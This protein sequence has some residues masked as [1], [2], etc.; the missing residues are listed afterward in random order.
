MTARRR[1][2]T[3][4]VD[5][6]PDFMIDAAAERL[7]AAGVKSTWFVTHSS[8]AVER[9]RTCSDLF[10]LGIH[11]NFR[12]GSSH[13]EDE[14]QVLDACLGMVPEAVSVRC[15]GLLQSS[16]LLNLFIER[17]PLRVCANVFLPGAAGLEVTVYRCKKGGIKQLPFYWEDDVEFFEPEPAWN[18]L[19]RSRDA[20]GIQIFNFHPVHVYLNAA[21]PHALE[22]LLERCPDLPAATRTHTEGLVSHADGA[23]S[24]FEALVTCIAGD[25]GGYTVSEL[26]GESPKVVPRASVS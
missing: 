19:A 3:L 20:P 7:V 17:T 11:P 23:G 16:R 12:P 9:L 14:L 4:D 15:H 2:I 10:E 22:T 25:G 21:G 5:W 18:P 13:G 6:A 26:A 24:M 8:P 1:A